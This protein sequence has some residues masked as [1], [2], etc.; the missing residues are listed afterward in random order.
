VFDLPTKE[1][2][3]MIFFAIEIR[4]AVALKRDSEMR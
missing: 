1:K 2:E 4:A 3:G